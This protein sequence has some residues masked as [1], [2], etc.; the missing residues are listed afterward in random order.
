M[1]ITDLKEIFRRLRDNQS[2]RLISDATGFDR[3]TIRS[4]RDR[5]IES[6]MMS[7]LPAESKE[8]LSQKLFSLLPDNERSSPI[9]DSFLRHKDEIMDLIT[10]T[11][12]PLKPKTAYLVIRQKYE[13]EGS[14]ESFKIFL[15]KQKLTLPAKKPFPRLEQEPGQET[16]IDYGKCGTITDPDTG[17]RR[18]VY[19]FI[20][21][22]SSSRLPYVE[23][24]YT[25]SQE[26]FVQSHVNM[27]EF[28][29][30]VTEYLTIDNLKA[31]VIKADVYD[32]QLNR[33]Y[34]EFAEHYGT[35][36]N[37]CIPGHAK[38]KAKVERQVPE[39]RE[40]FR[41]LCA[42]HP[43]YSLKDLNREA[44]EWCLKEYGLKPHGTTG[45]P[46]WEAF[47][48]W[49]QKELK[50]LPATR[51]EVPVWKTA[52][53]HMDQFISLDKNR[54]SLPIQYRCQ[55]VRCRRSGNLLKIYDQNYLFIRQ[56]Y[57]SSYKVHVSEGD[58][59]ESFEAM[60][61]G[62]YPR[63]LIRQAASFG[64]GAKALVESI[65]RPH[66][67]LNARRALGI[68]SVIKKYSEIPLLQDVCRKAAERRVTSSK[69]LTIMLEDEK[70]QQLLDFPVPRSPAGEAMIRDIKEYFY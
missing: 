6:G 28:F 10:R 64:P 5:M 40:L 67:F 15:R 38:G 21:K 39:I 19:G 3:K 50:P 22:L 25:Q 12:D 24:T 66:A 31:G 42:I 32:P 35:F 16:Q 57:I 30:G 51:F 45:V 69:Q 37:A 29:G 53:V 13:I 60:M 48:N 2:L 9:Q 55:T 43:T 14:Y 59:P 27:G 44:R 4:Y 54:F 65:L 70:N 61:Q 63:Y 62:E 1:D 7:K 18:V 58:F 41:R 68:L 36:I 23:F 26:S 56:Y 46:P 34:A 52:K 8:E 47:K 20:A 49:E 11:Q 33:S 17:K